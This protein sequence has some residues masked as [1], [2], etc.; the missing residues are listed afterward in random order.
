MSTFDRWLR[1]LLC[2]EESDGPLTVEQVSAM[3]NIP[4][5]TLY[6]YV[7]TLLKEDFLEAAG[8]PGAYVLGH[9]LLSLARK[10]PGVWDMAK[11]AY[12]EM[13]A[14]SQDIRETVLLLRRSGDAT[15]CVERV[16]ADQVVKFS[17]EKG[18]RLPLHAGASARI[19]MA[20]LPEEDVDRLIREGYLTRYTE[21]TIT[22]GEEIK[23]VLRETRENG[24]AISTEEMDAHVRAIAVPILDS[25][26][27]F[28][29][30]LSVVGPTF[31]L[32][33]AK[34]EEVLA[35]LKVCAHRLSEQFERH[36]VNNH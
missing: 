34:T 16:E 15:I 12:P 36:L 21:N 2:F 5:S 31:R 17:F 10:V 30:G 20:Y 8:R 26:G 24:Y 27:N 4:V 7:Q 32:D 18:K 28:L 29:A 33:A 9:R 23:R 6:R 14:L 35:K 13:Q 25:K 22:S 1:I 19:V 3:T 11:I